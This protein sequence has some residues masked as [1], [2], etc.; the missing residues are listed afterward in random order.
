[1]KRSTGSWETGN[2]RETW[3]H[4]R[5]S[6][7]TETLTAR[8]CAESGRKYWCCRREGSSAVVGRPQGATACPV[9]RWGGVACD[10]P[11]HPLQQEGNRSG[12]RH[13]LRTREVLSVG[14]TPTVVQT[15]CLLSAQSPQTHGC[16]GGTLPSPAVPHP[17]FPPF[18]ALPA[19]RHPQAVLG[20]GTNSQET[21][22]CPWGSRDRPHKVR[23]L[24]PSV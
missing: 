10:R 6:F 15:H 2:R 14:K 8:L 13:K 3:G 11:A 9:S 21:G 17:A 7:K 23:D 4:R 24:L 22:P 5:V 18:S 16:L 12:W 19:R 1:M 20:T